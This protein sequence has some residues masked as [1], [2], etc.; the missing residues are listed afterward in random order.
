[1]NTANFPIQFNLLVEAARLNLVLEADVQEHH[2]DI[3]YIVTNFRRS[4]HASRTV[5]PSIAIRK[6]GGQ[7]VHTDSGRATELSAAVG[8]AIDDRKG[9]ATEGAA[10]VPPGCRSYS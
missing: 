2:S 1:M 3:Y 5:L 10:G 9:G 6:E 8:R 4:G 7:W